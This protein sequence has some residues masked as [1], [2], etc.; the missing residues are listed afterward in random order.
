MIILTVLRLT[1]TETEELQQ[2][3]L[4]FQRCAI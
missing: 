2:N 4:E 3:A 1:S